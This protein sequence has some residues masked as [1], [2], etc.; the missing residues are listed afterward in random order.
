M[1]EVIVVYFRVCMGW[2]YFSL[3]SE[4]STL[5]AKCYGFC[6]VPFQIPLFLIMDFYTNKL[7]QI[8]LS[9]LTTP[10]GVHTQKRPGT[11]FS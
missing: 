9:F 4:L 1:A 10:D 2:W 8:P 6:Y 7:K 5:P 11:C 3:G